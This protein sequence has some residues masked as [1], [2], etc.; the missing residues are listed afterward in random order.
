MLQVDILGQNTLLD[1]VILHFDVLSPSMEYW[2][3]SEVNTVHVVAV[4]ENQILDRN[5]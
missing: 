3:P 2:V 4:E 5:A 1:E